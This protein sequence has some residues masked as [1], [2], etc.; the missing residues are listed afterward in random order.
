MHTYMHVNSCP[1]GKKRKM[2]F[3]QNATTTSEIIPNVQKTLTYI[4]KMYQ[5]MLTDIQT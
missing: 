1:C 3:Y 2:E 5:T 4:A